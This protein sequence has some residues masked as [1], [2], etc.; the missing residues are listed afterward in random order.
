MLLNI[1][2]VCPHCKGSIQARHTLEG[3]LGYCCYGRKLA[4]WK[5]NPVHGQWERI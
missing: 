5:F 3:V 4:T 2:E 1:G